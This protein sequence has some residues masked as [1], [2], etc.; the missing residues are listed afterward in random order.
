MEPANTKDFR[1]FQLTKLEESYQQHCYLTKQDR[2]K[3][4]A[5]LSMTVTEV[6]KWFQ[7]RRLKEKMNPSGS[8]QHSC[9]ICEKRRKCCNGINFHPSNFNTITTPWIPKQ[10]DC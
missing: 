5:K 8:R 9:W 3:I 6:G 4:A 10:S 2:E 7:A 1:E